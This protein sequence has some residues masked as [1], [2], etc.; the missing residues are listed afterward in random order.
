MASE[1]GE[2]GWL[3]FNGSD[4]SGARSAIWALLL[5]LGLAP[6]AWAKEKEPATL[7]VSGYGLLGNRQLKKSL[8]LLVEP[9]KKAES[10]DANFIE[11][12][13]L[14]LISRL[15]RDG[16][17]KPVVTARLTMEDGRQLSYEWR[18]PVRDEPLP[19]PLNVRKAEFQIDKGVLYYFGEVHF[20]GLTVV[21]DKTARSYFIETGT[22]IPFKRTRIFSPDRLERGLS[23]LNE[24]LNRQGYEGAAAAALQTNRNDQTG[25]VDLTIGVKE[26]LKSIVRSIRKEYFLEGIPDPQNVSTIQTNR[27]FSKL[28]LQDFIQELRATNYHLGYPDT[29]VE[30]SQLRH[31][32]VDEIIEVD[33]LA[34][35]KSGP[36]VRLGRVSF[37]GQKR[38]KEAVMDRRVHLQP[39]SLLDRV[40]VEEG[41]YRLARLGVF[42][43][44]GLTYRPVDEHTRDISYQVHE[45]K[46]IDFSLLFGY[47]SYELLRGGIEVE[48]NDI[49]GLAHH[50][51]LRLI[52]SI[53]A[54]Y[55]EYIYTMPELIGRDVD[56]F[57]NGSALR[58]QEI[59]FLREE[60]GGGF[61]GRKYINFIQSDVTARYNYQILSASEARIAAEEGLSNANVGSFITEI[62]HDRQD[63][64]LYPRKGYK[65]FGTF[66]V[67]SEYL[68]G[69]V[70]YQ[71]F[72]IRTGYHQPLDPGRWLHFGLSHGA[73][74]TLGSPAEDLPFNRR[75]FPGGD[76]SI[77]GYQQG[78]A[79]PRNAAGKI[80]GA[81]CYLFGSV[82]FEQSLTPAWSV[83]TFFDTV[84]FAQQIRD[85]PF[86]ESLFSVGGGIRWKT[87]IG[88]VRLEYGYNL[89]P[90]AHDPTGTIQFSLGFPF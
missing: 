86:N 16:Y 26:G 32:T 50:A 74:L 27:P 28:W 59:D 24:V 33:L 69:D 4:G 68:A 29:T 44:V 38:T 5:L 63:N 2:M 54:S 76:S 82:E 36:Q 3:K 37:T 71:R 55:G 80:V 65:I 12:A 17:L 70:N 58:R 13:V 20:N 60:Y 66:E 85:Y 48:Q 23:S 15:N 83:V 67:A 45:G 39:G 22:L 64:P 10:F 9:G 46:T 84:G 43:T 47:G 61:G 1:I 34:Q 8:Q 87:I 49:F 90:R 14:V 42:D 81:E 19:R 51:R 35:V 7:K 53:K 57:F 6:A 41:R 56:V 78:E 40:Q 79:A 52:Q 89:N 25:R 31:E 88:P 30:V 11:D 62:R 18:E 73:V 21:P 75:F 77:R 72:E